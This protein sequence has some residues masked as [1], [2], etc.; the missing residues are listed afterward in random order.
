M[1]TPDEADQV[2]G[3]EA[4]EEYAESVGIDPTPA[5]VEHY[6]E[7]EGDTPYGGETPLPEDLADPD[8]DLP[9]GKAEPAQAESA[10]A[11][12]AADTAARNDAER[13]ESALR[14]G[15]PLAPAD[16]YAASRREAPTEPGPG[17]SLA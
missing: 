3:S 9:A 8:G 2:I 15:G 11:D 10:E 17:T 6:L 1:S 16:P 5:E 4:A 7:L 12:A 14:V 13:M